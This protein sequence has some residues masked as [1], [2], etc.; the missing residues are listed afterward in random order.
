MGRDQNAVSGRSGKSCLFAAV[1]FH[2]TRDVGSR[3]LLAF[4]TARY[5]IFFLFF[6]R[7][8]LIVRFNLVI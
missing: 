5:G 6:Q 4:I 7:D 3:N 2:L 8:N 1:N